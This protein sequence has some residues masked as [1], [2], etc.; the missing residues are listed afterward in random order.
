MVNQV[1][2]TPCTQIKRGHDRRTQLLTTRTFNTR[3]RIITNNN[4]D[5]RRAIVPLSAIRMR[6]GGPLLKPRRLSRPNRPN[7]RTFTRPAT[8]KPRGRVFQSLL[9][10]HANT[11]GQATGLIVHRDFLSHTRIRAPILERFLVFAHGR[12]SFR[13]IESFVPKFPNP[14]RISKFTVSPKFSLTFSRR[15]HTQ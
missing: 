12:H 13:I 8:T 11:T 15:H 2:H 7:F 4:F 10:R 6:L 9:T 1:T 5:T 14:L 3:T